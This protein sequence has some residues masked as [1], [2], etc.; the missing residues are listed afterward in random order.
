MACMSGSGRCVCVEGVSIRIGFDG[1]KGEGEEQESR[2][3]SCD[4]TGNRTDDH[5]RHITLLS[6]DYRTDLPYLLSTASVTSQFVHNQLCVSEF[7]C[8]RLE[9]GL[10]FGGRFGICHTS[11]VGRSS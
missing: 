2:Q 9:V 1:W 3:G 5:Y 6:A 7:R 10:L 4:W 11:V 8:I